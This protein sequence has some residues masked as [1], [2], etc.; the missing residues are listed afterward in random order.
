[1]RSFG[2]ASAARPC[3]RLIKVPGAALSSPMFSPDGS[4]IAFLQCVG[5]CGDPQLAGTG[6]LWVMD[7]D[8]SD[9][10]L[11]LDQTTAG[12]QPF[13]YVDWGVSP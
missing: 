7:A 8:G 2:S 11:I 9:L 1:M 13:G 6:S 3:G 5:D 10:T 4:K 12:M